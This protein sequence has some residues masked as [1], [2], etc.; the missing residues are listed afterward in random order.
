MALLSVEEATRRIVSGAQ[1]LSAKP[2]TLMEAD[3]RVLAEHLQAGRTQPPFDASAMD[4]Y[5]VRAVDIQT[6]P[7]TLNVIGESAAGRRFDGSVGAGQAVRIFTGAPVPGGADAIVSQE[8]T[9]RNGEDVVV[10]RNDVEAGHIRKMGSDFREGQPLL[11]AGTLLSP[12][13]VTLAAAMGHARLRVIKKPRVAVVATGDELVLPGESTGPDQIVCS[14][15]F[16]IAGIIH[17]AGGEARFLGIAKDDRADLARLCEKARGFDLL[18]TVGGASVGDHDLVA[19]V[20][21]EMGMTLDFWRIAMR[22]G[23]PLMFG[24]LDSTFVIGLPGNPVS[25]LICARIF[26]VPL[27]SAMLGR[28]PHVDAL[29][30]AVTT[31]PMPVNGPRQHY[32]RAVSSAREDDGRL[33]VTPVPS[34]DSSLLSPLSRADVL[35]VRPPGDPAIS[36]GATVQIMHLDF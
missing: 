19:P 10:E 22:P 17:R 23:K 20:L 35:I 31:A 4:G 16:G 14:N 25:S 32:M 12:R 24:R 3:R 6:I 28:P 2:V 21:E 9:T 29:E 18:L 15:P 33:A 30:T 8:D 11:P 13:D 7:A 1:V 26:A 34:Q 5:A 27:I 36:E